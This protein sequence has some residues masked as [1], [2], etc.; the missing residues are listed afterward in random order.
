MKIK[1]TATTVTMSTYLD[2]CVAGC[3]FEFSRHQLGVYVPIRL[4]FNATPP[5]SGIRLQLTDTRV[6]AADASQRCYLYDFRLPQSSIHKSRFKDISS[7]CARAA[8]DV[9]FPPHISL[10]CYCNVFHC[11]TS[12]GLD[13][14][15]VSSSR[16]ICKS[17]K[18]SRIMVELCAT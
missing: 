4:T 11:E 8:V 17:L 12:T 18:Y 10:V 1:H 14:N 5:P 2:E 6:P 13:N 3:Y 7:L 9:I 15:F 16:L